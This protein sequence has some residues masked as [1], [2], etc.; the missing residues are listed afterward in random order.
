MPMLRFTYEDI[1]GTPLN[2]ERYELLLFRE[3]LNAR[4]AD[5]YGMVKY[6]R[7]LVDKRLQD[8]EDERKRLGLV[9][10]DPVKYAEIVRDCEEEQRKPD[11]ERGQSA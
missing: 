1:Y 3:E 9:D 8:I 2:Q 10:S 4:E 7:P 5:C 11:D 6:V